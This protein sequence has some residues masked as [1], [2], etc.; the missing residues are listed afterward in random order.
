[1]TEDFERC[2]AYHEGPH[3]VISFHFNKLVEH[4]C[5]SGDGD[6]IC[7]PHDDE[8]ISFDE[9]L[10]AQA[11]IES[12]K[13]YYFAKPNGL[14]ARKKGWEGDEKKVDWYLE[15]L[16]SRG[17]LH[18]KDKVEKVAASLVRQKWFLIHA[19]AMQVLSETKASGIFMY[20]GLYAKNLI[21]N[22]MARD[23]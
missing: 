6:G 8:S 15:V 1:M 19:L 5:L 22:L 16:K 9:I 23:S 20:P 21:D 14:K 10:I 7:S 18:D 4:I 2:T 3:A 12:D 11:G 13:A 17:E